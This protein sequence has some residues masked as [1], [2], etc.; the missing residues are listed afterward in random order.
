M[1]DEKG[2]SKPPGLKLNIVGPAGS[3][4]T[5]IANYLASDAPDRATFKPPASYAA[6]SGTKPCAQRRW[7][8]GALREDEIRG[9]T[10]QK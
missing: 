8:R 1:A 2:P 6:P 3:G 5:T 9:P 4:K 7:R 10:P